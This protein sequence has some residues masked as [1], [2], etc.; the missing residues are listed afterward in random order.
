MRK[1]MFLKSYLMKIAFLL[2]FLTGAAPTYSAV[3]PVDHQLDAPLLQELDVSGQDKKKAVPLMVFAQ[4]QMGGFNNEP[5]GE[6]IFLN[7]TEEGQSS[8]ISIESTQP[9]QYTAFKLLNP[10]R[11]ILDFPKMDKGNLT[12]RIQVDTGIVNS[13]RPIH[14]EVA[15]VLRLEIVLNQSA[16]YEINK[17]EKNKLIVRLR[18]S[19]QVSGQEMAQMSPSMKETAPSSNKKEFYKKSLRGTA[20]LMEEAEEVALNEDTCFPIL[21][22]EKEKISLDFQNADVR[23]LF[24]IFAEISGFN[25]ILSPEVGGS[26]NIRMID[27]PWNQAM[28]IILT[29]SALGREC[30]GGNIVRVATKVTLAA[31]DTARLS[32]KTRAVSE[33]LN[34]RDSEDLVTE[35]VRVNHADITELSTSL[36]ALKSARKDALITIDTRTNTL[37]LNDL[38]HHVD[39]M[40]ETIKILDISTPQVLIEAKI[41]EISKT[42]SQELGISWGLVNPEPGFPTVTGNST[43][44]T[45]FLV[46]LRPTVDIATGNVAGFDSLIQ[47]FLP[48]NIALNVRLEALEKSGKGRVISSPRVTTADNKEARVLSGRD[49][50]YQVNSVEGNSIQFVN[51]ELSLTV[52]PH[53]TSDNS[54]YMT[55][56]ATKNAADFAQLAAGIP[57]I[58]RK[59]MH[60]EVLVGNGETTVLAGIYESTS[61]E[62]KKAVPWFSKLPLVGFLFRAFDDKDTI[63][64]LLV[65]ITPTI[66]ETY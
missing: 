28:E 9:V 64:E 30:F 18:S 22:G 38:R 3:L 54:I 59:E 33:R 46:D 21:F 20:S 55:I 34:E 66:V 19:G 12:S 61:T 32:E 31:E 13:I 52:T 25:V 24:R 6:I 65:F 39:D 63:N 8:I 23:N 60:T 27:V 35:V 40:L 10:L 29:N 11:L 53:V 37:I 47:G 36:N 1:Q 56:D 42:F 48:G 62:N 57:T 7:T 14:F 41:V 58:T 51:A 43:F 17:P 5:L 15:G 26:V 50:P 44:D 16:D 45:Q 4:N 49:I 2:V